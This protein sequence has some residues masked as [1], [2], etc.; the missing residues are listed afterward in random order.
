MEKQGVSTTLRDI[1]T[2]DDA[3]AP[4]EPTPADTAPS[5]VTAPPP[6]EEGT[7]DPGTDMVNT[8]RREAFMLVAGAREEAERIIADARAEAARIT[9]EAAGVGGIV[10]LGDTAEELFTH[11]KS[12]IKRQKEFDTERR[13]LMRHIGELEL[14]RDALTRRIA[15]GDGA[16][17]DTT[18]EIALAPDDLTAALTTPLVATEDSEAQPEP[19]PDAAP[20]PADG[21]VTF[22]AP[23]APAPD[24]PAADAPEPAPEEPYEEYD[25]PDEQ[26][27]PLPPA[28]SRVASM[29]PRGETR[30]FYSRR[31]ARLPRIGEDAGRNALNSLSAMR[32]H[33]DDDE[34]EEE[35]APAAPPEDPAE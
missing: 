27:M 16:P 15:A 8:V 4:T 12:L 25:L 24:A 1:D 23:E 20:A 32:K 18:P 21:A 31:S 28:E 29:P 7:G 10:G 34:D 14:E 13:A 2:A 9:D 11:I 6:D 5:G 19:E 26:K 3:S 30:S 35:A 33:H 17:V 22:A